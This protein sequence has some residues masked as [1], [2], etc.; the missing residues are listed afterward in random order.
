LKN[1]CSTNAANFVKLFLL[2][3]FMA[4]ALGATAQSQTCTGS[5]GDPV[6]NQ[7][8]GS[9]S[10]PGPPLPAGFTDMTYTNNND[11]QD[12]SYTIAT[13]L[14]AG[15]NTHPYTWYNVPHDHTGNNN[16]YMMI[17]NAS[18]APSVFF[19]QT[20]SGL[21]PNTKYY[22]SAWIL[23]LMIPGPITAS[24]SH[25]DI[26]FSIETTDGVVQQTINT[27][28]IP[29]SP[30]NIGS[31]NWIQY[32]AFV[33]TP[34]NA[35][36]LVVKMTNNAPGGNGND[37]VLDDITFRACGPIIL[38][39]IGSVTGGSTAAICQGS[40]ATFNLQ[41]SVVGDNNPVY[42]WQSSYNNGNWDDISGGNADALA[43]NF[44]NTNQAG[45]YQY[46]MG[47]ANG[48]AIT[49]A[50]CRVYSSP[51]IF[52]I[53]P[54]PVVPAIPDQTICETYPLTLTAS[55]GVSYTWTGP[56]LLPTS[57]NP[58]II[59]NVTPANA[60]TYTVV[61]TSAGGC[62]A[63]PVHTTITVIPKVVPL[64]SAGVPVCA[65]ESTQLTAAGGKYYKWQPATG[66][67]HDDIPNPVASPQQTTTY[68]VHISN[69]G[70]ADS[71]KTVTVTVNQNP[72]AD[73]GN[74][75]ILF[76]GQSATLNG[77]VKGD[78]IT[79]YSWSP[80]TFLSNPDSL[81]PVTTPTDNIT[82]TLTATSQSCGISTS[83]VFVRVYKKILIPNAFSPNKDGTNDYWDVGG[84]VTYPESTVL[85]FNRY[86]Q[87]VYQ[88]T[89]YA[90]PW[91]GTYNG[92]ALPA[93]T[94][95]YI[96][97]LKNNTPKLSGWVVIIR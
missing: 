49:D 50:G 66:L 52:T 95:Y 59:N 74:N 65:G 55:G 56:A 88:S 84:L 17:V 15:N 33:T 81:D 30:F 9:G 45:T 70:C 4:F 72:V 34:A 25:P 71:S 53:N 39:G 2:L 46:R 27:G 61:A 58:L 26:T 24:Y 19:T 23:N 77:S 21:C 75:I 43:V 28:P 31:T 10:N 97:D 18:Y 78:N 22:F 5:L 44:T 1:S 8:F 47:V 79:G 6:I 20:A 93:G 54:L 94:Y 41:A 32:G 60:G 38:S 90:K 40:P 64:V 67:N 73:A 80:S 35:T 87:Q 83:S 36:T 16:G 62:P 48:S 76:E 37:F 3:I 85:V 51:V 96:I 12:G 69:D 29:A 91:D 57:Q 68:T 63:S 11:P 82:Y 7:D 89:G 42:Q 14:T 86:G 92:S 13:N